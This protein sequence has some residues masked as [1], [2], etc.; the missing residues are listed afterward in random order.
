MTEK[1]RKTAISK[2]KSEIKVLQ[3]LQSKNPEVVDRIEAYKRA[4]KALEHYDELEDTLTRLVELKE[5]RDK[6]G[7]TEHYTKERPILW[8]KARRLINEIKPF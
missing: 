8:D 7:K 6:F 4:A 2:L 3:D 5:Y 1:Q